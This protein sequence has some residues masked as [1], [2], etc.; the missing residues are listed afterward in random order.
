MTQHKI[1]KKTPQKTTSQTFFVAIVIHFTLWQNLIFSEK[2]Q[3]LTGLLAW[4]ERS[5][6]VR[7]TGFQS[8][9]ESYQRFKKWYMML[10]CLTQHYKVRIKVK[11]SNQRNGVAPSPTLWCSS[12]WKGSLLV[13]LDNFLFLSKTTLIKVSKIF[14]IFKTCLNFQD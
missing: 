3:S 14:N 1:K 12:Y 6:M 4:V 7:E 2:H 9:V 13:T 8:P 10:P 5:P 11:W